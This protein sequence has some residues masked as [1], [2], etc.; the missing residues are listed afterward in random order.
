M[1]MVIS[2][3]TSRLTLEVLGI[4]NFGI[5]NVV[6]GFVGMM[7]IFSGTVTASISRYL[8][9]GLG[10]GDMEE[11]KRLFS[12]SLNVLFTLSA[13][14]VIVGESFGL[15]FIFHK[16]NI[17]SDRISAAHWV[18]QCSLLSFI[19]NLISV[20]Y[21]ASIISHEKMGVFAYMTMLDVVVKLLFVY[22]LFITPFDVLITYSVLLC[23]VGIMMRVI[24]GVYCSRHFEECHYKQVFDKAI[25]KDMAGFAGWNF[26][27]NTAYIMNT[28]G[29]N[30][31][32][33]VFFGVALNAARGVVGQVEGAVMNLVN[34]FTVAFT[35]Q[36]T[37]SYAEG[38]LDYTYSI[39][40][41]GTKFSIY[42][43]LY[44]IIPLCIEAD[45]VLH[46]WLKE[47]P[48]QTAQFLILTLICNA[49]L[50][51]GSAA[52][53]A[54]MATGNI[55]NYQISVT[56]IAC[57][58]FPLT[59]LSY[60]L[61]CPASS[62]YYIYMSVY[63][64]LVFYRM[65]FLKRILNFP[66]RMYLTESILPIIYVSIIA[67]LI[68]LSVSILVGDGILRLFV[69][70]ICSLISTS[71]TIYVIGLTKNERVSV[72]FK[73]KTIFSRIKRSI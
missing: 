47:V 44:I 17:P 68:P 14:I 62:T 27:G 40:C 60:R 23:F 43:L 54:I 69:V 53:T 18:F 25:F 24:Y 34:N 33:N 3:F 72:N 59:W 57:L 48:P 49:S 39:V 21:N 6:G 12:T 13:I 65:K 36:I 41:R 58:I 64:F 50:L 10:K 2:L 55:R 38:N 51:M 52:Y 73:A 11:L 37:K 28:Q 66:I 16:L 67:V 61:G 1:T 63:I 8:T 5:Y 19:V 15:W 35:P 31:T 71:A 30:M 29:V 70:V 42:L 46:L 4:D 26:L 32:I 20:P 22:C 45:T 9:F 7:I 56:L